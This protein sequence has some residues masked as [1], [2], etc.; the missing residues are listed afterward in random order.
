MVRM[1]EKRPALWCLPSTTPDRQGDTC[2]VQRSRGQLGEIIQGSV[3]QHLH[4]SGCGL[5][6]ENIQV[7]TGYIYGTGLGKRP[8][9]KQGR[10]LFNFHMR[11]CTHMCILL[12]S[13]HIDILRDFILLMGVCMYKWRPGEGLGSPELQLQVVWATWCWRWE[14]NLC[15]PQEL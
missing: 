5:C 12:V 13:I 2:V 8:K 11:I 14:L 3:F 9:E 1:L 10:E 7:W 6:F 15:P 4:L